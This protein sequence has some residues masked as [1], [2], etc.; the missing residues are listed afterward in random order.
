MA[1]RLSREPG[2][3]TIVLER[4]AW[5]DPVLL[6]PLIATRMKLARADAVRV[7]R[8]QRG[9]LIEG[10]ERVAA[11]DLCV[12]LGEQGHAAAVVPDA[13]FPVLPRPINVS[14]AAITPEG[15][16]TLSI[17]GAGLPPV[18]QWGNLA[19]VAAGIILDPALHA[20]ALADKLDEV[21]L[22]EAQDRQALARAA[23]ERAHTRVFPLAE[24]LQRG[25]PEVAHAVEA[26]MRGGRSGPHEALGGFGYIATAIDIVFTRPFERLR[27]T[28]QGRIQGLLRSAYTA[29]NLYATV[30]EF[31]ARADA[32]MLSGTTLAVVAGADS[33]EYLFEDLAQF[34]D[35][36]RWAYFWRLRNKAG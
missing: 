33:G 3:F 7:C 29:R 5:L 26:A 27:L 23:I 9:I 30:K 18:W 1:V 36:C 10:A 2:R 31:E 14:M 25:E 19:L 17:Q 34:D 24:E 28:D 6:A 12:R 13:E 16:A 35:Y 21:A 4:T 15:L 22:E 32:A 11:E 8:L 20:A